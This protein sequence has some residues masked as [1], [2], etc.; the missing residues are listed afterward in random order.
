[1]FRNPQNNSI[2][3]CYDFFSLQD[4][5]DAGIKKGYLTHILANNYKDE[6]LIIKIS[7]KGFTWTPF[8]EDL[9]VLVLMFVVFFSFSFTTVDIKA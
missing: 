9:Y 8:L 6:N 3:T 7:N 4:I 2:F 1:M 5:P